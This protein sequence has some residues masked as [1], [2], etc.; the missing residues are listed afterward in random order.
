MTFDISIKEKAY[1]V[2]TSNR[3]VRRGNSYFR[4]W[5]DGILQVVKFEYETHGKYYDLSF[6]LFSMYGELMPQWFTSGGS[7]TKYPVVNFIGKRSSFYLESDGCFRKIH[8]VSPEKQL[9][10]FSDV[11]LTWLNQITTQNELANGICFLDK[12]LYGEIIWNDSLKYAPYLFSGNLE[13]AEKVIQAILAQYAFAIERNR[14]LL[15]PEEFHIYHS[16]LLDEINLLEKKLHISQA[17]EK[18]K[19]SEYLNTNYV[20]NMQLAKFCLK[21]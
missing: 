21:T 9:S 8:S 6:G 17:P 7:I 5:G 20:E 13:K 12:Q 3:F 15:D 2:F 16:C 14:S 4:V 19:I 1:N 18:E 11:V 10:I